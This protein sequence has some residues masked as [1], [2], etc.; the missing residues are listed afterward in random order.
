[1]VNE[2][3]QKPLPTFVTKLDIPVYFHMGQ[4]DYKTSAKAAKDYF[5][6]ITAPEKEF[7]LYSKSAHYPQFEEKDKFDEW[8]IKKF[9]NASN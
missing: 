1:M 2:L 4:Y 9:S 8:M 3:L 7:I 5:D 6:S